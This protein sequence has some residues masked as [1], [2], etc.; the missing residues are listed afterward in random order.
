MTVYGNHEGIQYQ[1]H[2]SRDDTWSWTFQPIEGPQR[3]G[4]LEGEYEQAVAVVQRS[5]E[6]SM[7]I[8]AA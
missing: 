1:L 6:V 2:S 4:R 5:I 8:N 3:Y 7:L